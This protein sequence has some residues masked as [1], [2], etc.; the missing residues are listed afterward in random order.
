MIRKHPIITF[1]LLGGIIASYVSWCAR[2]FFLHPRIVLLPSRIN[3][4]EH[5]RDAAVPIITKWVRVAAKH[6]PEMFGPEK[7]T[8]SSFWY[9]L[10]NPYV[11]VRPFT[12]DG[13]ETSLSVSVRGA[14]A[15]FRIVDG[16][17]EFAQMSYPRKMSS[18]FWRGTT[19]ICFDAPEISYRPR[20]GAPENPLASMLFNSQDSTEEK[21]GT[22][23]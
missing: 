22:S 6:R 12:V 10:K 2:P 13:F 7:F 23:K 15:G 4:L 14:S 1:V 20:L 16:Q 19:K 8:L 18:I 21:N 17:W 9:H 11:E 5:T 3:S